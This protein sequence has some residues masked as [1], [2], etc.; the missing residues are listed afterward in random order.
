MRCDTR[1]SDLW[2]VFALLDMLSVGEWI[3]LLASVYR[4]MSIVVMRW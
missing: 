3:D 4:G 1:S 2:H